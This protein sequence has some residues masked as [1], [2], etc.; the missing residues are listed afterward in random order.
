MSILTEKLPDYIEVNNKKYPINS[1]FRHWIKVTGIVFGNDS[2]FK[3]LANVFCEVFSELPDAP[4][5]EILSAVMSFYSPP[6]KINATENN[7]AGKRQYDFDYDA[8]LIYSAFLQQYG[9]DLSCVKMH[10]WQF[11][12]LFDGLNDSTQFIKVVGYRSIKLSD[13]KDKEQKKYYRKMKQLYK[14]PDTRTQ[15]EKEQAMNDMFEK[16]F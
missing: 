14:L 9:I 10:W 4:A 6:Q 16:M 11:K 15:E 3:K 5:G 7:K 13:I 1:D 8:E 12:A 2:E